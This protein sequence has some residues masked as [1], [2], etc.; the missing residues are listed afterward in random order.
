MS[1]KPGIIFQADLSCETM[2]WEMMAGFLDKSL[3]L[4]TWV[5][6]AVRLYLVSQACDSLGAAVDAA[7]K[8]GSVLNNHEFHC[9]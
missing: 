5:I 7:G 4:E 8:G 3:W 6:W 9:Q 2:T 1:V